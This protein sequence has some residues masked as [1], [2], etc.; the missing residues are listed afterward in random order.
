MRWTVQKKKKPEQLTR[1]CSFCQRKIERDIFVDDLLFPDENV[2]PMQMGNHV[3]DNENYGEISVYY[4]TTWK[5][6]V[7]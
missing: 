1:Q 3:Y 6:E 4:V 2:T 5:D 7:K